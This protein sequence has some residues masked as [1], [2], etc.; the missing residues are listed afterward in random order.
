MFPCERRCVARARTW[1]V[2]LCAAVAAVQLVAGS[3]T[4]AA[5]K[6]VRVFTVA[7]RLRTA[8]IVTY[9]TF[10]DK[11]FAMM[12]AAFPGRAALV[13]AGVDDVASHIQPSDPLAPPDV[14]VNFPEDVGLAP[15]FIGSRGAGARAGALSSQ[16]YLSLF[17]R[18]QKPILF[19]RA[20][21]RAHPADIPAQVVLGV[22]DTV[23]RAF[24]ETFRDIA[25]TYGVYVSAGA[26]L[27]PARIVTQAEDPDTYD[28]LID[29]DERATRNYVYMAISPIVYNSTFL[30]MPDGEVFV[31][32]EDGS[33][34]S[35]PTGTGG[36]FRGTTNKVYLTPPELQLLKLSD[37]PIDEFDALNTPLG[38]IGF[39]ISKDAW[40]IDINDRLAARHAHLLV[41]SEAFSTWAFQEDPWDPDIFKQGGYNNLQKHADFLYN[42]APA[43][44]GNLFDIT[45]DG[46]SAILGKAAKGPLGPLDG[47][48]AWIGQNPTRGF[49]AVAPWIVPDPGIADPLLTLAQRR[50]ALVADGQALLPGS[51]VACPDPLAWGSCENGYRESVLWADL[52]LPDGLDVLTTPDTTPPAATSYGLSVQV[53][54]EDDGSP[55]SQSA[56]R[57]LADG[58]K[59]YVVWQDTREGRDAVYAAMS[60]DGGATW[61]S[62]IKVSDNPVGSTTE[63]LPAPAFHRDPKTNVA[64]LYIVWQESAGEGV[65]NG[66]VKLARFDEN[67]TKI[68][69]DVRV[70]DVD[71]V[72]KWSPLVT[73]VRRKGV[74]VVVWVDERDLG[75]EGSVFEHL[76]VARSRGR[77]GSDRRPQL[78]FRPSRP[79]VRKK[80]LDPLA[81]GLANEWA[82]A[83]VR[84]DRRL[85]LVWLDYR[86]YNWDVYAAASSRSG[87]RFKPRTG[88][89]LDDSLEFERLN[90][91]PS[92]AY[93]D[94]S[95]T[96]IAVWSDQRERH[97]DTDIYGAT[98][99]DLGRSW[100]T[101]V[102]IDSADGGFDP[103][104]D[105]ASNQWQPAVAA[106]GGRVCVV[107]QDDRLGDNDV[108]AAVSQDGGATFSPDERVDDSGSGASGQYEPDAAVAGG[109]CYVAWVDN[110]SGDSDIRFASRAF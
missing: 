72:G 5:A 25:T 47:T 100:S 4:T 98:S 23:Y 89:R 39:V 12:D 36:V 82:P 94:A 95:G 67:L 77:L 10:R 2:C 75:P 91:H 90:S 28:A 68:G 64:T 14:L 41:Q 104:H 17:N 1:I 15:A 62:D 53:N 38:R 86:S 32:L 83:L 24:Y 46:Q 40:M 70:D 6:T 101:P 106:G 109:R 45:F 7:N 78:A 65:G 73:T 105:V 30:F 26:N 59:L 81:A 16:A 22:T 33:V 74:P 69:A 108:F 85:A 43:L 76:R 97:P 55:A 13:Q 60:A 11:M 54:D 110:R 58:Q 48:N 42:V 107:W 31:Q 49:L 52:D 51:G 27:P 29:P 84:A 56:P 88:L 93:D 96:L 92:I 50:A 3:A 99:A 20:L 102:R 19:Y 37:A 8:D 87:L 80:D 18:Y 66:Q 21:Y 71:G 44:T 57:I 35:A 63:L 79:V 34:T 103:D 61:S 9:Q